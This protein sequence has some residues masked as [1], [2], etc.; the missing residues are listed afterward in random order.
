MELALSVPQV[1]AHRVIRATLAGPEL[2]DRD[3]K[4]FQMMVDEKHAAF[5][6]AW[7]DMLMH[8]FRANQ[9]FTASMLRCFFAPFSYS[10]PSPA[11]AAAR[12]Q[13]AAIG[14]LGKGLAPFHRKAASNAR[15]LAKTRLS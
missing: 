5:A 1:A 9:A 10:R 8:A 13:N 4:E 14:V 15:R 12:Y 2:S 7:R 11:S 6:R 3:R